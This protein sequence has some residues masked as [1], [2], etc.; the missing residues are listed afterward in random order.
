MNEWFPEQYSAAHK[1]NLAAFYGLAHLAFENLHKLTALNLQATKA[2]L[3]D[4]QNMLLSTHQQDLFAQQSTRSA[5]QV[6]RLQSYHQALYEI[7]LTTQAELAT[8]AGTRFEAYN[9][10]VQALFDDATRQMPASSAAAVVALKRVMGSSHALYDSVNKSV[11]QAV[12]MAES[13]VEAV[14]PSSTSQSV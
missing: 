13:S 12:H 14:L 7:A 10:R 9:Q 8:L 5:V 3:A 1:A 2:A 11:R 6:E 4:T